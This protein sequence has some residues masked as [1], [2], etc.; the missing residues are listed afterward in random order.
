MNVM[1][2][3]YKLGMIAAVALSMTACEVHDP[4]DDVL[5][6][7]QP[8]PT[9]T[10]ALGGTVANAGDEVAFEGKYYTEPGK[11][12]DHSEVWANV[13]KTES[14]AA[15]SALT[16]SLKYTQTVSL[17]D[18]V[19]ASQVI[20]TYPHSMAEWDGHEFV[21]NATFPTSQTLRAVSWT[22]I[23]DWDQERFDSYYPADFAADFVSTVI[24]YLTQ[25]ST[26]YNDLRN[27]YI[28]YD[29]TPEQIQGVNAAHAGYEI[30]VETDAGNKS[31]L[32]YTNTENVVGKYYVEIVGETSVIHE[33]SL[34]EWDENDDTRTYYDVYESSPWVFCRYN[35]DAGAIVTSVRA[36]YMPTFIDLLNLIPF[37]DWIHNTSDQVYNVTFTRNYSQDVVFKVVDTDGNVSYTTDQYTVTIN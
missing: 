29:F 26:Y 27:V 2:M 28:N 33:I 7:G 31:D 12:P 32:W 36:Q 6:V 18:T 22:N 17:T 3:Q 35:D 30:P 10:W 34:D 5:E 25:D 20:A 15:T 4:F 16:T 21:L 14:A 23:S 1:K 24:D 13:V 19:R 11:T 9:V 8:V 37:T